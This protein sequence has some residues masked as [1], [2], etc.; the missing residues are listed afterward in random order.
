MKVTLSL[1]ANEDCISGLLKSG[2]RNVGGR[3][4]QKIA[5]VFLRHTFT[6]PAQIPFWA[7]GWP[8]NRIAS[9]ILA[10]ET[11]FGF[12][13]YIKV[14]LGTGLIPPGPLSVGF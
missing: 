12:L 7:K 8:K 5:I 1:E 11:G 6:E 3:F 14:R 13:W 10:L 4:R 2:A 9:V